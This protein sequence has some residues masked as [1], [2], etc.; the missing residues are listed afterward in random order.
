MNGSF[1]LGL[2]V[3]LA[4]CWF[5]LVACGVRPQDAII[6]RWDSVE[7]PTTNIV[8]GEMGIGSLE[9]FKEGTVSVVMTG[10]VLGNPVSVPATGNYR[11]V[12]DEHLR[13]EFNGD[14]LSPRLYRVTVSRDELTLM[15]QNSQSYRFR[16]SS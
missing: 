1:K 2:Y 13:A 8:I 3:F 4:G 9:F 15:D 10:R 5:F 12:D 7:G 14:N 11:F 6:G 16:R